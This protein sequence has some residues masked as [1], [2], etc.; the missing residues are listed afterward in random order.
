[1]VLLSEVDDWQTGQDGCNVVFGDKAVAVE[2]VDLEDEVGLLVKRR[3]KDSEKARQELPLVDVSIVVSVQHIE[4]S[5]A[6]NSGELGV[7][8]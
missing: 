4:E 2:V 7:V 6:Q 5:V 1:M 8:Q 3:T